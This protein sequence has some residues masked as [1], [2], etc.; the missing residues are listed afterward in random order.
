MSVPRAIALG[1]LSLFHVIQPDLFFYQVRW[2]IL[3]P[4]PESIRAR[5]KTARSL[6]ICIS[7]LAQYDR[8]L[9]TAPLLYIPH[10][11]ALIPA[12]FAL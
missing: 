3:N 4:F 8:P 1:Q 11:I 10:L 2:Q 9:E 6:A 7:R 5:L 12:P